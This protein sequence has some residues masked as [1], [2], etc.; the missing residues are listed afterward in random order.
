[1]FPFLHKHGGSSLLV[2]GQWGD[3]NIQLHLLPGHE[4]SIKDAIADAASDLS[5]WCEV[6]LAFYML[7][8]YDDIPTAIGAWM[9]CLDLRKYATG[10]CIVSEHDHFVSLYN[11]AVGEGKLNLPALAT[12][13]QQHELVKQRVRVAFADTAGPYR[14]AWT[15]PDSDLNPPPVLGVEIMK[16]IFT[17]SAFYSGIQDWLFLFENCALKI[18]NE[19]V[20]ESMGSVMSKHCALSR[21]SLNQATLVQETRVAWNGPSLAECNPLLKDALTRHFGGPNWRFTSKVSRSSAV[22]PKSAVVAR[23]EKERS[24]LSSLFS[25]S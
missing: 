4:G 2:N 16:T 20:V 6:V 14:R 13:Q 22:K 9:T 7:R 21:G 10:I 17:C 1:M 19:E 24:P 15:A 8:I 11:W 5:E 12:L 25:S 3:E 18:I 23:L